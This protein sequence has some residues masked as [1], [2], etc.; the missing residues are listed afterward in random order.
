MRRVFNLGIGYALVVRPT[1][2]NAIVRRLE[3][4][5]ERPGLIGRIE[6][7]SGTVRLTS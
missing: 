4:L 7:G 3:R 5:G 1:F 6:S 2:A